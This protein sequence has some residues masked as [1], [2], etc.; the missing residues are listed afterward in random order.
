MKPPV[1]HETIRPI[2]T[3]IIDTELTVHRHVHHYV[4]RI[5]PVIVSSFEEERLAHDILGQG[6]P[7]T[8]NAM[9]REST[10][11]EGSD[12]MCRLC[13]AD[14][15]LLSH[16]GSLKSR[17][18]EASSTG[19]CPVCGSD[20]GVVGVS[21]DAKGMGTSR[22]SNVLDGEPAVPGGIGGSD[23]TGGATVVQDGER[24]RWG[25]GA[26]PADRERGI[27]P[28]GGESEGDLARGI[29]EMKISQ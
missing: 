18:N 29:R 25:F 22:E 19:A 2:E 27:A 23:V 3:E 26:N 21:R 24:S 5:Q 15:N 14:G 1:V 7:S 20:R 12:K 16:I 4:H 10:L 8:G 28:T 13:G 17:N 9:Y 11:Q 6:Q